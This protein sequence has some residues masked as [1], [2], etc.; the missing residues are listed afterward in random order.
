MMGKLDDENAVRHGDGP[1]ASPTPMRDITFNV[2][3]VNHN[4]RITP[5]RPG[6]NASKIRNGSVND[7]NCATMIRYIYIPASASA[8]TWVTDE[9]CPNLGVLSTLGDSR[10]RWS[11]MQSLMSYARSTFW[12]IGII[13]IL[14]GLYA[15]IAIAVS[16]KPTPRPHGAALGIA[17]CLLLVALG[18]LCCLAAR[19]WRHK[20][21]F[22]R[23]LVAYS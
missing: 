4:L 23:P 3:P 2:V 12:M 10:C 1:P 9:T 13:Q 16:H 7:R 18:V 22:A 19:A 15:A 21:R 6:G 5:T 17:V 20:K 8:K 11:C 14:A